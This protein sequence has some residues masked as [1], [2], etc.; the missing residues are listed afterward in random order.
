MADMVEG[1]LEDELK[2]LEEGRAED[3]AAAGEGDDAAKA[4]AAAAGD[5]D[6]GEG[7]GKS[8]DK[9]AD[10]KAGEADKGGEGDKTAA[11][12]DTGDGK[13]GETDTGADSGDKPDAS[14]ATRQAVPD[15]QAPEDAK[16][17]IEEIDQQR[18]GLAERFDN[19]EITA[20]EMRAEDLK[21]ER[22]A[23]EIERAVEKA[24]MAKDMAEDVWQQTTVPTFLDQHKHY[25]GN[26]TLLGMLDTEVRR[27][28]VEA[29]KAGKSPLDA[30]ILIDA[31]EAIK[32]ALKGLTGEAPA[33]DKKPGEGEGDKKPGAKAAETKAADGDK[34][35]GKPEIPPTLGKVPAA[36][37]SDTDS[38]FAALDRLGTDDPIA[39][40]E[41]MAR[42]SNA[43][44]ERYLASSH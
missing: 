29:S 7:D 44:R 22:Q 11:A 36:D 16:A 8:G 38:A 21:L 35:P 15:W 9:T 17:K 43:D 31:D 25:K 6:K 28:Q 33:G 4:A 20:K 37:I 10:A 41:A 3:A 32:N 1:M 26:Q 39:L 12:A 2:A 19:G 13:T 18:L 23:R 34:K 5:G 24:E 14:A 30:Q 40:E 27:L 42:M